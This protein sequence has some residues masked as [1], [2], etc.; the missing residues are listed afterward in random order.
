MTDTQIIEL[1]N[2]PKN[3]SKHESTHHKE[4]VFE[5]P[6]W[7]V[8]PLRKR[9]HEFLIRSCIQKSKPSNQS[10]LFDGTENKRGCCV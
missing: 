2:P 7:H 10:K 4:T 3:D 8:Y 5:E 1:D 6:N 9:S